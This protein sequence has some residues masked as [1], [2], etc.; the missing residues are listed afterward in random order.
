MNDDPIDK[1]KEEL[2]QKMEQYKQTELDCRPTLFDKILESI[3]AACFT[4]VPICVAICIAIY[5]I[6]TRM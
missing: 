6:K 5:T 2:R 4:V 1:M 3:A